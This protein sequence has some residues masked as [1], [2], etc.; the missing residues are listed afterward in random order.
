MIFSAVNISYPHRRLLLPLALVPLVRI[1]SLSI[2]LAGIP[3]IWWYP[4]IYAPLFIACIVVMRISHFRA[5]QVGLTVGKWY[6]QLLIML[7]GYLVGVG[8]YLILKPQA[9]ITNLTFQEII[10]P[11]IILT[12]STG[13][14]EELIFRGVLQRAAVDSFGNWGLVYISLLFAVMHMGYLSLIDVVF[15]FAV[16]MIFSFIV[17][18][19]GSL[20]GVS[21]AHGTANVVLYLVFPLL[22]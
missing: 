14:V 1:I 4:I 11:A 5:K 10:L 6:V 8:E 13:F 22:K 17:K 18:F 16:A 9:L 15:V 20:L 19:T 3:Q 2:P 7:I 12:L 21:L